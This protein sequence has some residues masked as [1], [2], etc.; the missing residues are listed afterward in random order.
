MSK[1]I[2]K[3]KHWSAR[4]KECAVCR[5]ARGELGV[6]LRGGAEN[7]EFP[8]IGKV[9]VRQEEGQLLAEGDL[10]LEVEGLPVSGL[11]LYD[12]LTLVKNCKGPVRLRTVKQAHILTSVLLCGNILAQT[13]ALQPRPFESGSYGC[14]KLI[15][16]FVTL[17]PPMALCAV[18]PV[19]FSAPVRSCSAAMPAWPKLA[20][21][22]LLLESLS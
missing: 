13:T 15:G 3:K 5:D 11:P 21:E 4:L 19:V 16:F 7:G 18:L 20:A 17:S 10:L 2:Q 14:T 12:V 1:V 6:E 8:Y 22:G 9:R